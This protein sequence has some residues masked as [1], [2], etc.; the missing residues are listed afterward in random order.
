MAG[1]ESFGVVFFRELVAGAT[2]CYVRPRSNATCPSSSGLSRVEL[3][4]HSSLTRSVDSYPRQKKKK[5]ENNFVCCLTS[6]HSSVRRAGCSV[7]YLPVRRSEVEKG[8]ALTAFVIHV[9]RE[10][11]CSTQS[12]AFRSRNS[13]LNVG[14]MCCMLYA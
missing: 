6:R 2:C 8:M 7:V 13:C 14:V 5:K 11:R 12:L 4:E 10:I 1:L 3:R 9:L